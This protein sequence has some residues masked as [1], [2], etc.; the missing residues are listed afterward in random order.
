MSYTKN[1]KQ[2]ISLLGGV[3]ITWSSIL[4]IV[5]K[6]DFGYKGFPLSYWSGYWGM[7]NNWFFLLPTFILDVIFWSLVIFAIIKFVTVSR[8]K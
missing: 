5:D 3:L 1:K 8:S 2:E 6:G 4:Y 7:E